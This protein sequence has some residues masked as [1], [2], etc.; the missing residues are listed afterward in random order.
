MLKSITRMCRW[1][2]LIKSCQIL[3]MSKTCWVPSDSS[4]L[5]LRDLWTQ[6]S[7]ILWIYGLKCLLTRLVSW[8]R[9][10]CPS[11]V[12]S[13]FRITLSSTL[14]KWRLKCISKMRNWSSCSRPWRSDRSV[15]PKERS[16][17]RI[18]M[19]RLRRRRTKNEHHLTLLILSPHCISKFDNL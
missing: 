10:V 4:N 8:S 15:E 19:K 16:S 1:S 3:M 14:S 6:K 11:S 12:S 18:K 13:C 2:S 17:S 7:L 5:Q 9:S